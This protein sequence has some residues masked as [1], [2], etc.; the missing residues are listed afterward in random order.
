MPPNHEAFS[1]NFAFLS[2]HNPHLARLP[3]L[4]EL[5][6]HDDPEGALT[7][8][9]QFGD[10]LARLILASSGN[11]SQGTSRYLEVLTHLRRLGWIPFKEL[12]GLDKLRRPRFSSRSVRRFGVLR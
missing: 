11:D 1:P 7:K 8:L 3:T 9:R 4:A 5:Y 10:Q 6:V 12:E 2:E